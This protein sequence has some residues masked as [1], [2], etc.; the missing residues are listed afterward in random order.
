[1]SLTR[2]KNEYQKNMN[3]IGLGVDRDTKINPSTQFKFKKKRICAELNRLLIQKVYK[4]KSILQI[5]ISLVNGNVEETEF[6]NDISF[7]TNLF[8]PTNI[9]SDLA[10][11]FIKNIIFNNNIKEDSVFK[12]IIESVKKIK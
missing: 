2:Y 8:L 9:T 10:V 6:S 11:N 3:C 1:M 5:N 12:R 7:S 4:M